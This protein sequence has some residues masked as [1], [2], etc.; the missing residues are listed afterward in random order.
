VKKHEIKPFH[1][2]KKGKLC[3]SQQTSTGKNW[4][5]I[6]EKWKDLNNDKN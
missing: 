3:N 2:G 4:K 1:S 6:R 5:R